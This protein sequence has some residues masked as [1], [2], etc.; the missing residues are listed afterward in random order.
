MIVATAVL[1]NICIDNNELQPPELTEAEE[2]AFNVANS[3]N[4]NNVDQRNQNFFVRDEVVNYFNN[5]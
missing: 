5:L 1:H 4:D 2:R 3:V